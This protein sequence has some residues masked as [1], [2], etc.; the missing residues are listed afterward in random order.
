MS[1]H[2]FKGLIGQP[3]D[4]VDGPLKVS[5]RATY[6]ADWRGDNAPPHR[7]HRRIAGREGADR[8]RIDTKAAEACDGVEARRD[9]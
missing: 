1:E 2:E 8:R 4:R 9:A 6:A 3:L 5:G 7:L